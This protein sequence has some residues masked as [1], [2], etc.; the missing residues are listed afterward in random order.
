MPKALASKTVRD[1]NVTGLTSG[2]A[3]TFICAAHD[4]SNDIDRQ[5]TRQY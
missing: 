2:E 4:S 5:H 1:I 3:Y